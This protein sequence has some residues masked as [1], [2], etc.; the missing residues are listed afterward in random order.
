[1]ETIRSARDPEGYAWFPLI[2]NALADLLPG[3]AISHALADRTVWEAER[4]RYIRNAVAGGDP[5]K[6]LGGMRGLDY[7]GLIHEMEG[8]AQAE[9]ST[10]VRERHLAKAMTSHAQSLREIGVNPDRL[11]EVTTIR[12][13]SQFPDEALRIAGIQP[14]N[15]AQAR[16]LTAAA[17]ELTLEQLMTMDERGTRVDWKRS[18][19][20]TVKGPDNKT[21]KAAQEAILNATEKVAVALIN[22]NPER[23]VYLVF[24]ME[25][26]KTVLGQ[27]SQSGHPISEDQVR[28]SQRRFDQRMQRARPAV[29]IEWVH[30]KHPDGEIV[31]AIM[32]GR[33]RG[34]GMR[35]SFGTWPRRSG[36]DTYDADLATLA[37]WVAEEDPN[38]RQILETRAEHNQRLTQ[39][40]GEMV[41]GQRKQELRQR[42]EAFA[43]LDIIG[44]A[45][46][47]DGGGSVQVR[48]IGGIEPAIAVEVWVFREG[49]VSLGR[50]VAISSQTQEDIPIGPVD[51]KLAEA[52]FSDW[53][54]QR[55][56]AGEY[57]AGLR[58]HGLQRDD[59][60]GIKAWKY[61][62]ADNPRRE[63]VDEWD[64]ALH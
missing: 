19:Y 40:L 60:Y 33:R 34:T 54:S 29:K 21:D 63:L 10:I 24:G 4:K 36:E 57:L 25:D 52:P 41:E 64:Q 14:S 18:I 9:E 43:R 56:E 37:G 44:S 62:P 6:Q 16:E 11:L 20:N 12:E 3:P 35:T 5:M 38:L 42:D 8:L 48:H 47:G 59:H 53:Q 7:E 39:L 17:T 30:F 49:I 23:A 55:L 15:E 22:A 2:L 58:W 32:R 50:E 27:V 46:Q 13:G 45:L 51:V 31:V 61:G 1:M 26:D 28:E